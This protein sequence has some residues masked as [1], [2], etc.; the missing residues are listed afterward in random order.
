M[1]GY[2]DHSWAV[3]PSAGAELGKEEGLAPLSALVATWEGI[4]TDVIAG[5]LG[6]NALSASENRARPFP[7]LTVGNTEMDSANWVPG[8]HFSPD[9]EAGTIPGDSGRT[10]RQRASFPSFRALST[11]GPDRRP[12]GLTRAPAVPDPG[13]NPTTAPRDV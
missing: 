11:R 12:A 2:T 1:P 5:S 3:W 6:G 10:R 13:S 8:S 4:V 7:T 9:Q